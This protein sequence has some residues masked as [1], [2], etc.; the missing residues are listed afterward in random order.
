M[1]DKFPSNQRTDSPEYLKRKK[2][3]SHLVTVYGRKPVLEVLEDQKLDIFRLHLAESNRSGGIVDQIKQIAR[4]R[5]IEVLHHSRN[6]LSRIS[7]N[8]KQ[9]QGVCLLYTSPSPR[10]RS[11]SRMPSSA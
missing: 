7:R 9:D 11:L 3:F 1:T 5:N 2:F 8:S 10:D 6:E 4:Q